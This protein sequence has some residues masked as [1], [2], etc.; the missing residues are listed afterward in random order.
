MPRPNAE[1]PARRYHVSGQSV[2]TIAGRDVYLGPHDSAES[3]ARYA[4]LMQVYQDGGLSLPPRR[5]RACRSGIRASC[6]TLPLPLFAQHS[7]SRKC[8]HCWDTRKRPCRLTRP[9]NR[10][11]RQYGL[12]TSHR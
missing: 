7:V 8:K 10:T 3:I 6:V 4:V 11:M 1:A 2:V 5:R 9:V 12:R